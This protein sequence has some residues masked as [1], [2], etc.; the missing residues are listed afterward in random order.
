MMVYIGDMD[1]KADLDI[2]SKCSSTTKLCGSTA[3]SQCTN[4]QDS[5][6][7]SW[8]GYIGKKKNP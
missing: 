1:V 4:E 7:R 6:P 2:T 3:L 8:F 5:W